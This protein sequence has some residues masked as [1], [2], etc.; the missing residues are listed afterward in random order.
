[1]SGCAVITDG[2]YD[3][4]RRGGVNGKANSNV[5]MIQLK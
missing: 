4:H 5:I 2:M 3:W 1:M